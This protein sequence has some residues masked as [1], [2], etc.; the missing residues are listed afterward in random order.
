VPLSSPT[1][2]LFGP[3]SVF[4]DGLSSP[5]LIALLSGP[6]SPLNHRP[7]AGPLRSQVLNETFLFL[8]P[9]L[10]TVLPARGSEPA[11]GPFYQNVFGCAVDSP[12]VNTRSPIT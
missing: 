1:G 8:L 11:R 3:S 4:S 7:W 2:A 6:P 10:L 12:V 5:L 9:I